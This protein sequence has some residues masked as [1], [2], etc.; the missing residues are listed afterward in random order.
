MRLVRRKIVIVSHLRLDNYDWRLVLT[1]ETNTKVTT[2]ADRYLDV[3][4][5][6]FTPPDEHNLRLRTV[7]VWYATRPSSPQQGLVD[8]KGEPVKLSDGDGNLLDTEVIIQTAWS[9]HKAGQNP[10]YIVDRDDV[11]GLRK[12]L[13]KIDADFD[14]RDMESL[15]EEFNKEDESDDDTDA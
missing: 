13:D 5:E 4:H 11:A 9:L 8:L 1:P 12:L 15:T 7:D 2:V 14:R 10:F 3:E 6:Y